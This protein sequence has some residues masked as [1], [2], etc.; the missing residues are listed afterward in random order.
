MFADDTNL[1]FSHRDINVLFEKMKKELTNV[2]DWF[3]ANNLSLN[4]KKT[5]HS[6]FHKSLKKSNIPLQLPNL[7]INELTVER[8]SSMKFL[9][10]WIDEDLTWR[11]RIHT[12][13]NK[14]EKKYWTLISR[15]ALP[16]QELS[17]ANLLCLHTCLSKL[18]KHSTGKKI[19]SIKKH[20]LRIIFNQSKTSPFE[21]LFS[22]LN[23]QNVYQ[24]NIFQS[25][26]FIDKIKNKNVPYNFLIVF[27]VPCHDYPTSF[28]LISFSVPRTFLKVTRF[29]ILARGP[30]LWNNCKNEKE[31]DNIL[32]FKQ[33][34][35]E[36]IMELS[37]AANFFQ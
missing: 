27:G 12:V 33:R 13:E 18:F 2:S 35:K 30:L 9:G 34:A 10:V 26:Q 14:I 37:T 23:V 6:F 20:A 8:E 29:A 25:V 5:K 1:F 17:Q 24:I 15:K 22:S 3:N 16:R 4:V 36:K 11:D 7:N 32:L 21:P 19:Q 31:I 28:S